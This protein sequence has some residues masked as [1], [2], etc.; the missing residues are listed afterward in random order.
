MFAGGRRLRAG[1]TTVSTERTP[2]TSDN[3]GP[4]RGLG[5]SGVLARPAH[6]PA[7]VRDHRSIVEYEDRH[8]RRAAQACHFGTVC[9]A[10]RAL[11]RDETVALDGADLVGVAGLVERSRGSTARVTDLPEG[12]L[13]PAR[14]QDHVA[15]LLE[16]PSARGSRV[17]SVGPR[18]RPDRLEVPH[19]RGS[20][21]RRRSRGRS[22]IRRRA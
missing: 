6:D 21:D 18:W 7:R 12:L 17:V 9:L 1:R 8:L 4:T 13:Q 14:I 20:G 22:R 5:G 3:R 15:S 11:P 2:G 10:T 19:P 16:V